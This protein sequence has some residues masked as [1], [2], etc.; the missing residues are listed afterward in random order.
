MPLDTCITNVGEYYSSHYLDST[1]TK[2]VK[3]LVARWKD[4]GAQAAPRRLQNLSQYYFFVN[5]WVARTVGT[6]EQHSLN[7]AY[8]LESGLVKSGLERLADSFKNLHINCLE[9]FLPRFR[10]GRLNIFTVTSEPSEKSSLSRKNRLFDA[11]IHS[12]L[13]SCVIEMTEFVVRGLPLVKSNGQVC[14]PNG[15]LYGDVFCLQSCS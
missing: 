9:V 3:D 13:D 11:V 8:Q 5:L 15:F 2:D 10:L 14:S 7:A 6:V 12:F 1:F 4:Q